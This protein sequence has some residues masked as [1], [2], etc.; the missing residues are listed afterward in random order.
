MEIMIMRFGRYH[1]AVS[2]KL[3]IDGQQLCGTLENGDTLLPPGRYELRHDGRR[4]TT[5]YY[6]KVKPSCHKASPGMPRPG[7]RRVLL[8]P[9]N[10][11]EGS[12][13]QARILLGET[14]YL[15]FLI[16]SREAYELV[17]SRLRMQLQGRHR[18]VSVLIRQSDDYFEAA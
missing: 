13:M 12:K 9:G 4:S 6:I 10:G 15:G 16:H 2:G 11:V 8:S 18:P 3:L 5:P 17:T 7:L 14:A 1:H